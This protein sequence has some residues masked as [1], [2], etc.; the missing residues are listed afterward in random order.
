MERIPYAFMTLA[1]LYLGTKALTR[2]R[3]IFL[4]RP[5][6]GTYSTLS[7]DVRLLLKRR[8]SSLTKLKDK[9]SLLDLY[10]GLHL[11]PPRTRLPR[12]Q[13]FLPYAVIKKLAENDPS[14]A[15]LVKELKVGQVEIERAFKRIQKVDKDFGGALLLDVSSRSMKVREEVKGYW[16]RV[17]TL[18]TRY[19]DSVYIAG[20]HPLS[21][22]NDEWL[23]VLDVNTL[24]FIMLLHLSEEARKSRVLLIGIAKDTT[25]TDVT[26]AVLPFA[27]ES[28]HLNPRASL[29]KLKSD[30]AF[31]TILSSTNE[32]VR[33]PWRTVGYDSAFSTLIHTNDPSK[34]F[35]SARKVVSQE[36][37][38]VRSFFQLRTLRSDPHLR[39]PVFLFD[40]LCDDGED[41]DS[42]VQL[43]VHER[44][45]AAT[46]EPYFEG[47]LPSRLSNLILHILSLADNPEVFEAYGHNQLLYLADKA[48]KAEVRL[49]RNALRAVADLRVGGV[50]TR[51]RI[52][53]ITT[54][55][56]QQRSEAEEA[57]MRAASAER[58]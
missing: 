28:G 12:R 3:L 21:L 26:R 52:Y 42:E 38:F 8:E 5:I 17:V 1:E 57:R 30:R 36:Q 48:V 55:Y 43:E 33:T 10:L 23:T 51:K 13:R 34:R 11:G 56:R 58:E 4:D 2:S 9:V 54:T 18:A 22:P 15:N 39:S 19:A 32:R 25:A 46:I 31:L 40:R 50:S 45:G 16:N 37:L 20:D 27:I 24:S 47:E 53:G 14:P 41:R 49:S 7:R 6:S 35:V 29:P 44:S